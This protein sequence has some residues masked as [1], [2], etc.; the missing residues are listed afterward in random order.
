MTDDSVATSSVLESLTIDSISVANTLAALTI[1]GVLLP[2]LNVTGSTALTITGALGATIG[3]V[4]A[5]GNSGGLTLTGAP[6]A[7]VLSI[8]GSS[9]ADVLAASAGNVNVSGGAGNDIP[10]SY[11]HL[12]LPTTPYV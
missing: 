11:T 2:S 6:G 12:T 1:D 5:S 9:A 10:V 8:T 3:S 7:A 4:D